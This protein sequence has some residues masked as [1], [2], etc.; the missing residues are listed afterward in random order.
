MSSSESR[1]ALEAKIREALT[2]QHTSSK[3]ALFLS[4]EKSQ[5]DK[6]LAAMEKKQYK[7]GEVI[8]KKGTPSW[9]FAPPLRLRPPFLII[10]LI[11]SFYWANLCV[12]YD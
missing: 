7:A 12:T 6:L 2:K 5:V 8:V 9:C 11:Y 4:L 3:A 10:Q 1:H